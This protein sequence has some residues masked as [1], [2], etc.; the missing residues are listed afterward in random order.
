MSHDQHPESP[1]DSG[2]P[3][4]ADDTS[5]AYDRGTRPSFEDPVALPG[6]EAVG[7]DD[8]GVTPAEETA[9]E[10]LDAR[11]AREVP[12]DQDDFDETAD[13]QMADEPPYLYDDEVGHSVGRL[14]APDQG[15]GSDLEDEDVAYDS[16]ETEGQSA[17]EAA[18]HTVGEDDVPF[19]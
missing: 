15:G 16:G 3:G 19:E 7:V 10:P 17:E 13:V 1:E 5:S 2:I 12:D 14:V 4:Y 9:G 8:F 18:M 6:D 11:I